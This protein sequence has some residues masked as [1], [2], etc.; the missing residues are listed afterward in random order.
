MKSKHSIYQKGFTLI[1]LM[2]VIAIIGILAAIALPM[3][4]DMIARAQVR[5][6]YYEVST[7]RTAI[8]TVMFNGNTATLDKTK[9]GTTIGGNTYEYVGVDGNKPQSTLIYT[10]KITPN[11]EN[12]QNIEAQFG[13]SAHSGI[14]GAKMILHYSVSEGWYCSID[15]SAAAVWKETYTPVNCQVKS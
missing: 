12:I 11:E 9:D 7:M 10:I 8:E 1:E 3:Y 15:T 13:K 2:I 6:V 5:R 14:A 4:Q